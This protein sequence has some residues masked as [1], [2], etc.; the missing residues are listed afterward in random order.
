VLLILAPHDDLHIKQKSASV[1]RTGPPIGAAD[2]ALMITGQAH[3]SGGGYA[4]GRRP[5]LLMCASALFDAAGR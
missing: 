1:T 3:R 2:T 4:A 5:D